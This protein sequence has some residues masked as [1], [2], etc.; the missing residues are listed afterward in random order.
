M[1][2]FLDTNIIIF[3]FAGQTKVFKSNIAKILSNPKNKFYASAISLNEI[4]Q[5]LRKKRIAGIDYDKYDTSEKALNYIL[6]VLKGFIDFLPYE[7]K[8]SRIVSRLEYAP[9]HNDP[10]DLSIIAHS[11]SKKMP[12]ISSDKKFSFYKSQ[13][14]E[15]VSNPL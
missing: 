2:Y 13:G 4:V 5:L 7:P 8:Y 3:L 15:V 11:I 14:L 6:R 9:R 12:I 10:N 1:K